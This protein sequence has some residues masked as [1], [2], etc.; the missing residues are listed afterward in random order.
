VG[1]AQVRIT[2]AADKREK[3]KSIF[4]MESYNRIFLLPKNIHFGNF[5]DARLSGRQM[6]NGQQA[7]KHPNRGKWW[8]YNLAQIC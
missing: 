2:A 4:I 5:S 6:R 1:G 8:T 7:E 3:S